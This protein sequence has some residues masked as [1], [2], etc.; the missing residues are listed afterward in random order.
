MEFVSTGELAELMGVAVTEVIQAG[1]NLG[2]MVSINQRLDADAI[3]L[4]ADEFNFEVEFQTDVGLD[5]LEFEEDDPEDLVARGRPWSR[6]WATSTTVRRRCS[7]TS[8]RPTSSRARPAAS[9][10]TSAPTPS[11]SRMGATSPSSTRR[12]TRPSPPCAPAAPR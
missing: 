10:S 9:P 5:D 4:L 2:M 1:F 3:T 8:A 6:S 11:S 7:T 12:A